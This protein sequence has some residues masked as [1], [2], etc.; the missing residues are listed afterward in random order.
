MKCPMC[1]TQM[2]KGACPRCKYKSDAKGLGMIGCALS[3]RDFRV[4]AAAPFGEAPGATPNLQGQTDQV[5]NEA[6]QK[7]HNCQVLLQ[8]TLQFLQ[9]LQAQAGGMAPPALQFMV[10]AV[11]AAAKA[12]NETM[13]QAPQG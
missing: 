11:T 7:F 13:A 4:T 12:M 3:D 1:K 6:V 9:Q 10:G 2:V 8:E 5:Q